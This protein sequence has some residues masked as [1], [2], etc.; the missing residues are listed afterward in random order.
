MRHPRSHAA[1]VQDTDSGDIVARPLRVPQVGCL[2]L[3][4]PPDPRCRAS[5]NNHRVHSETPGSSPQPNPMARSS[6][7]IR[8][9]I[10]RRHDLIRSVERSPCTPKDEPLFP[11]RKPFAFRSISH[12]SEH[13][14]CRSRSV[15]IR[16]Q[17]QGMR[18][19]PTRHHANVRQLV[20]SASHRT[21]VLT[22][23]TPEPSVARSE[24]M[25]SRSFEHRHRPAWK[26][27]G[28]KQPTSKTAHCRCSDCRPPTAP[29][30]PQGM[31]G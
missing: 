27:V 5:S 10:V 26:F 14:V 20:G 3:R 12:Q 1:F 9:S 2:S 30:V 23:V 22:S 19:H 29:L 18:Q 21:S 28:S 17:P 7:P 15:P 25:S 16:H 24:L 8:R 6:S 13:P 4:R 31:T 11:P